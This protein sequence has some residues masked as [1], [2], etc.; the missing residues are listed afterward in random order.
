MATS[1]LMW[2][3]YDEYAFADVKKPFGTEQVSKYQFVNFFNID[4]NLFFKTITQVRDYPL[5]LPRN[6]VSV[7]ILNDTNNTILSKEVILWKNMEKSTMTVKHTIIQPNRF[8]SEIVDG[9]FAGTK[10]SLDFNETNFGTEVTTNIELHSRN[11]DSFTN[12]PISDFKEVNKSILDEFYNYAIISQDSY[13]REVD[14]IFRQLLYRPAGVEGL[15]YFVPLLESGKD[16]IG[17]IQ[18]DISNSD[19]KKHLLA[20]NET[21]PMSSLSYDTKKSINDLYMEILGRPV[22]E[23]SLVYYGSLLQNGKYGITDIRNE[24]LQSDEEHIL[25][26]YQ[27]IDPNTKSAIDNIFQEVLYRHANKYDIVYY[28]TQFQSGK[29][30]LSDIK[31]EL[32]KSDE[33]TIL[34]YRTAVQSPFFTTSDLNFKYVKLVQDLYQKILHRSPSIYETLVYVTLLENGK[35][36]ETNVSNSIS[37]T[38][39][40]KLLNDWGVL[41]NDTINTVKKSYEEILKRP[42]DID[43]IVFHGL[44]LKDGFYKNTEELKQA[45]MA[46]KTKNN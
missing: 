9:D 5:I 21:L 42:A 35:Y 41:D 15:D 17:D 19:E 37:H 40:D 22:D 10:I 34:N 30:S 31:N 36:N 7:E 29:Y 46:S 3:I 38:D 24:L 25:T 27:K 14:D 8:V 2:T 26:E 32:E 33:K 16:S 6:Y 45:L 4:K 13:K 20:P 23:D 39:Q 18:K 44:M 43:G 12:F 28:G 11:I 1:F